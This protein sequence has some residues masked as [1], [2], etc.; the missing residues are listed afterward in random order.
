[1][2]P[3]AL[4]ASWGPPRRHGIRLERSVP[5]G[6]SE[7][8]CQ[9]SG[10]DR[11]AVAII[12]FAASGV[13]RTVTIDVAPGER[14]TLLSVARD[15]GVPILFNCE[16]G[17]CGACLVHVDTVAVGERPLAPLTEP[18]KF[19]LQSMHRLTEHDIE[20][21]QQRGVPPHVRLAC[22]YALG[23]EEIVVSFMSDLGSH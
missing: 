23:D 17:G 4:W 14:R 6:E 22:Q 12:H 11:E 20:A 10:T 1:M 21:A 7:G 18:E 19:L 2:S 16:A 8:A 3:P 9:E 5:G 15:H 13:D